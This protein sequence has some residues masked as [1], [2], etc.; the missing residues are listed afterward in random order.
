MNDEVQLTPFLIEF[1][2]ILSFSVLEGRS[3]F[4]QHSLL[5]FPTDRPTFFCNLLLLI[6]TVL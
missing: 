4:L 3:S 5:G 1:N 6:L 2:G